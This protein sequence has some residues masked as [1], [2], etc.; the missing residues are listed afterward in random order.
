MQNLSRSSL[1]AN[2][3]T[4]VTAPEVDELPLP[5]RCFRVHDERGRLVGLAGVPRVPVG[6]AGDGLGGG[7]AALGHGGQGGPGAVLRGR[8]ALEASVAGVGMG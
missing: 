4:K 8:G 5:R 7:G 3:K 6:A 2:S 1:D